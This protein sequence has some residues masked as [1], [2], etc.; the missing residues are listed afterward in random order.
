LKSEIC[1][2]KSVPPPRRLRPPQF[3]LRTLLLLMAAIG[4]ALTLGQWLPPLTVACLVLLALSILAHVAGNVIGTKLR[5]IGDDPAANEHAS[6]FFAKRRPAQA[7]DFAPTTQLGRR[8][9]LGWPIVIG[10]LSGVVLGG[11]GGG[12]WTLL[13]SRGPIGL[14]PV[15]VGIIAFAV[16]GGI[17][18]FLVFGFIQVGI[19][20]IRQANRG[21]EHLGHK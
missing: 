7:R 12:L 21:S 5:D 9:N 19:G 4:L 2:L 20:A 18:T 14:F 6:G 10:T 13:A 8:T 3:G 11:L 17:A 16:L 15:A 1:D